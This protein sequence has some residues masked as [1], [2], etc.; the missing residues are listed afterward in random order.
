[1]LFLE[2]PQ[3]RSRKKLLRLPRGNLFCPP[4][5]TQG[6]GI[7]EL[8]LRETFCTNTPRTG[9][10]GKT[11]D[12][13]VAIINSLLI[14]LGSLKTEFHSGYFIFFA[15][16]CGLCA[17]PAQGPLQLIT[18]WLM[19]EMKRGQTVP[20]GAFKNGNRRGQ[21]EQAGKPQLPSGEFSSPLNQLMLS[22]SIGHSVGKKRDNFT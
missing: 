1:M 4:A 16:L 22:H 7:S 18:I 13:L 12:H 19:K 3:L 9:V 14:F 15:L 17:I 10:Q 5:L 20:E 11:R 6:M 21:K 8:R 2:T